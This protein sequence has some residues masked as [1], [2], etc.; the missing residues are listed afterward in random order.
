MTS[1]IIY[2]TKDKLQHKMGRLAVA[3]WTVAAMPKRF[4][5]DNEEDKVYF[6]YDGM[7][8]GYFKTDYSPM[9]QGERI[10]EPSI[11]WYPPSWKE[12]PKKIPIKPF[13]GFKYADK[14]KELAEVSKEE[15]P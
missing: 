3:Y 6:A 10:P 9:Y 8:Q 1:I 14:V 7:I 11:K 13:Q 5:N 2:T 15:E 4:D 12:L